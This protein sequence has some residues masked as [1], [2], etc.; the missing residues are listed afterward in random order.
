M[1]DNPKRKLLTFHKDTL[2]HSDSMEPKDSAIIRL[3]C[4][5]KPH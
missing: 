1:G 3:A 4:T 5:V 2:T